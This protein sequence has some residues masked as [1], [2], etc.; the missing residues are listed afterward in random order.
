MVFLR[1][2]F[3]LCFYRA[4]FWGPFPALGV[5]SQHFNQPSARGLGPT[6]PRTERVPS[7]G[8]LA[9]GPEKPWAPLLPSVPDRRGEES[10]F[11]VVIPVSTVFLRYCMAPKLFPLSC[12]EMWLVSP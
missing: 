12:R 4:N 3:S 9:Q 6:T 7:C 8:C 10:P 5:L 11:G 2:T 1:D